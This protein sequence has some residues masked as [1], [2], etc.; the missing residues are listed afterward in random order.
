MKRVLLDVSI[1]KKRVLSGQQ[2]GHIVPIGPCFAIIGTNIEN[3]C[4]DWVSKCC[5]RDGNRD[6]VSR[7]WKQKGLIRTTDETPCFGY[8][9][10]NW[11]IVL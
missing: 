5:N 3:P 6:V 10:P 11:E 7:F 9:A 4:L 2:S 1:F 8:Y